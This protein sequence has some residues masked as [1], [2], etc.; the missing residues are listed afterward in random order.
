MGEERFISV[1]ELAD[2]L[3]SFVLVDCDTAEAYHRFHLPGAFLAPCRYWKGR[4]TDDEVHAIDDP[5]LLSALLSK[6]GLSANSQVVGYDGWGGLNAA[7]LGWTLERFGF[8][9]FQVLDGGP[10]NW[11]QAGLELTRKPPSPVTSSFP[12]QGPSLES[13]CSMSEVV[14]LPSTTVLWDNRSPQ[15]WRGGRIPGATFL[16]WDTL[17]ESSGLL[18]PREQLEQLLEESGLFKTREIVIYCAGGIRAAHSYWVL[19]SLGYK[20]VRVYDG[21]WSEYQSSGLPVEV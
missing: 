21:S 11:Y 5:A 14:K 3:E 2:N 1:Q 7:R 6:L 19:K 18:L 12:F 4:G 9:R 16:P 17:L 20:S 10:E 8:Q 15:E 13:F